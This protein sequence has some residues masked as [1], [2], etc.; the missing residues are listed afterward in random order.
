MQGPVEGERQTTDLAREARRRALW[1]VVYFP[2]GMAAIGDVGAALSLTTSRATNP[3]VHISNYAVAAA[4]GAVIGI[5]YWLWAKWS[6]RRYHAE[7]VEWLL[8]SPGTR[9]G[10]KLHSRL[11][12]PSLLVVV[13]MVVGSHTI[14]SLFLVGRPVSDVLMINV[15]LAGP[16]A[17]RDYLA[18]VTEALKRKRGQVAHSAG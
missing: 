6:Y 1:H 9:L 16:L 15:L 12:W 11:M 7:W 5:P 8:M 4:F 10:S 14:P 18:A 3:P 2:L 13:G 17:F